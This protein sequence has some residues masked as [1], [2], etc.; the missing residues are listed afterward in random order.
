M[1]IACLKLYKKVLIS[2][3]NYVQDLYS[4][5]GMNLLSLTLSATTTI[6]STPCILSCP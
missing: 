3:F 5:N 6:L 4:K 2:D 1:Y